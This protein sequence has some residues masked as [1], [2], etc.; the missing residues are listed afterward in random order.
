VLVKQVIT[1]LM[2]LCKTIT[3]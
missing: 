3:G 2:Q 1:F